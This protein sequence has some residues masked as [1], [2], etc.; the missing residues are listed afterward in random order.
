MPASAPRLISGQIKQNCSHRS[1]SSPLPRP[2]LASCHEIDLIYPPV[3]HHLLLLS[4]PSPP[5]TSPP[6]LHAPSFW[7]SCSL[8]ALGSTCDLLGAHA[9]DTLLDMRNLEPRETPGREDRR[10]LSCAV[11]PR[12]DDNLSIICAIFSLPSKDRTDLFTFVKV[13]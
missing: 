12:V 1:L 9:R 4:S 10:F 6:L 5:N 13:R 2:S 7:R 3:H 8:H 11:M